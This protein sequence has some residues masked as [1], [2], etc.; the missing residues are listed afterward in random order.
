MVATAKQFSILSK[1]EYTLFLDVKGISRDGWYLDSGDTCNMTRDCDLFQPPSAL[2][3]RNLV[4]GGVHIS[5]IVGRREGV[6]ALQLESGWTLTFTGLL[7]VPSLRV[8]LLL[9]CSLE[10]Q[11]HS[12]EFKGKSVYLCLDWTK[13][14]QDAIMIG[15]REGRIYRVWVHPIQRL[16]GSQR[17]HVVSY[18][19]YL[20]EKEAIL[21]RPT[22]WEWSQLNEMGYTD[23]FNTI[24]VGWY[25]VGGS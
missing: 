13:C 11:G 7:Y 14:P 18:L 5:A 1:E 8:S 22:W 21:S 16:K 6:V 2:L 19:V 3:T 24:I 12:M 15:I 20:R 23:N 10:D 4:R 9:V 25:S 17:S